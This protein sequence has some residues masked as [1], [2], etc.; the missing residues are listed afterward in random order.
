MPFFH[1]DNKFTICTTDGE[2]LPN[3]GA[4]FLNIF[5]AGEKIVTHEYASTATDR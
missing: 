4:T 5:S 2:D 3:A 1:I